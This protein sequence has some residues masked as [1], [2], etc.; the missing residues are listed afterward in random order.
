MKKMLCFA[1]MLVA[2][3]HTMA[4]A[5][6]PEQP[7]KLVVVIVID[8]FAHHYLN[9]L[10]PFFCDGFKF[11]LTNGI[12]Y[13][14]A[15]QPHGAPSTAPGHAGL[16]TGT[17]PHD[18]GVILNGWLDEEGEKVTF[19]DDASP[20]AEVFNA[21]TGSI[22][23]SAHQVMVETLSDSLM[24]ASSP[25]KKHTVFSLSYKA[26]AAI[27]MAG[28]RGNPIW[29]DT[30]S[31]QFTSSKAFFEKL[32]E[33][34]EAFNKKHTIAKKTCV[35]W[36]LRF[37]KDSQAYNFPFINNRTFATYKQK[38]AGTTI[39]LNR[40]ANII[41]ADADDDDDFAHVHG[42]SL[43]LKTPAANK[44][45]LD[46]A[47]TCLCKN[48]SRTQ[49]GTFLLWVSLSSLDML[50]HKYGPDS[51]E[52]IDMLYHLDKQL[53]TFITFCQRQAGAKDTLFALTADHGVESI[54]EVLQKKGF[55]LAKR[56][57]AKSLIKKMN[58]YIERKYGI[59]EGIAYFKVNQ[60]YLNTKTVPTNQR[61]GIL[62]ALKNFMRKQPGVKNVWTRD[63]LLAAFFN[64][65]DIENLFKNQ[66]HPTRSGDLICM[67]HAFC[68]LS[69]HTSGTAHRTSYDHDTHIPLI[70]YR[71][72][73]GKACS[74]S[75]RVWAPQ[76][77][78]TLAQLIGVPKPSSARFEC[79]PDC[80]VLCPS[81]E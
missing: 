26:R 17:I 72:G 25:E 2:T 30:K 29:F 63:E 61:N 62:Q 37:N 74:I 28:K 67:P 66:C 23:K 34:V 78:V 16:S 8:Q 10:S 18:H 81:K 71:Q 39:N 53:G 45:L 40:D 14:K 9:K 80:S 79:L 57:A 4:Y 42:A 52:V 35:D 58:A 3:I 5:V 46:F 33:W 69:K 75:Q 49:S 13:D 22:G 1:L 36:K 50:G 77:P 51:L 24:L 21:P 12:C 65:S 56:I 19:S 7:P 48:F 27:C 15:Y 11:L 55:S 20:T 31:I 64:E 59:Q 68:A 38:L 60:F 44:M 43:F 73:S 6:A 41:A 47:Q 32:P 76:L 70:L 54:P